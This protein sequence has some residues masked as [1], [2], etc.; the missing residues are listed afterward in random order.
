M[1][2]LGFGF[3]RFQ[4]KGADYDWDAISRMAD[5][6]LERGGRY[7]DT[8]YTYLGGASE[9]AIRRCV[10][11]RSPRDRVEICD[12][13][14]GYQ[15]KTEADTARYFEEMRKRCGTDY[16]DV[17]MLHWLNGEN[18]ATA[19]RLDQFRF[20]EEQKK[21]GNAVRTGFSYHDSAELLDEILTRHPEVDVVQIQLNYLDWNSAGIQSRLCYETCVKHGKQVLV[22]E[23]LRGGSLVKLPKE[24]EA[25]LKQLRPDLGPAAMGLLFAMSRPEV[26]I[27][28]SGMNELSQVEENMADFAPL[29]EAEEEALLSLSDLITG[30]TKVPC[31]GCRYCE[32]HCPMNIPIPDCFAMYNELA[33]VPGDDWKI[34]PSY[35][36]LTLDRGKASACLACGACARHC[37]QHIPIPEHM[38]EAAKALEK[39]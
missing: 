17:L 33:R 10:V 4:K 27:V 13:I 21:A 29:T 39:A 35:E 5:R 12:K 18:Y 37:P 28:L 8:C 2:K 14:P 30:S 24:A 11:E 3:L 26:E 25:V 38:K 16:F 7:F 34:R 9:E 22:M 32:P 1:N 15:C 23:P 19:E 20:I 31:T 6:F 36:S